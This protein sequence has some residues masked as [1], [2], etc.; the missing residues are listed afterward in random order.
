MNKIV[1]LTK[2]SLLFYE[3]GKYTGRWVSLDRRWDRHH[4][5]PQLRNG[6][7]THSAE[8]LPGGEGARS[9]LRESNGNL[10]RLGGDTF[11]MD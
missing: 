1:F 8:V 3:V 11:I 9:D 6:A 2:L 5:Q 7:H 10:V 4:H